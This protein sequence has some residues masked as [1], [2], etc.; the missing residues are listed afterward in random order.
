VV[1]PL[2]WTYLKAFCIN[3]PL[4]PWF[5]YDPEQ[6]TNCYS[7]KLVN[8]FPPMANNDSTAPT[9]EKAQHDPHD[10]WFLTEETTP[11][12]LQSTG[13]ALTL[14]S[15]IVA[16]IKPSAVG[17]SP[18]YMAV[19]SSLVMSMNSFC[20][21]V[22]PLFLAFSDSMKCLFSLKTL[23]LYAKISLSP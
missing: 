13:E 10:P 4:H 18:K 5:P 21:K 2:F 11:L 3:P 19:N 22:Y 1:N 12:V 9:A 15:P 17:V 14:F 16:S 6:S 7:D 20:P 23:S 8:P